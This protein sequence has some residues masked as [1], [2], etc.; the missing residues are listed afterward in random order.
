MILHQKPGQNL[1]LIQSLDGKLNFIPPTKIFIYL[2]IYNFTIE[3][4]KSIQ[5]IVQ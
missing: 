4:T 2:F 5:I 3:H 1:Y